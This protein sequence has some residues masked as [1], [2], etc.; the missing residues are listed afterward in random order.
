MTSLS[1]GTSAACGIGMMLAARLA[2]KS[3]LHDRQLEV[4]VPVNLT[5]VRAAVCLGRCLLPAWRSRRHDTRD[6]DAG[7]MLQGSLRRELCDDRWDTGTAL[8]GV[9]TRWHGGERT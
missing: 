6:V 2:R 3:Y 5:V 9:S 1:S 7:S 4:L 8:G